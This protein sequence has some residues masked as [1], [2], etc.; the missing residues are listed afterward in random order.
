M[1][2]QSIASH[3][4]SG[5]WLLF[6]IFPLVAAW[7]LADV[8]ARIAAIAAILGFAAV[9][10]A[11]LSRSNIYQDNAPKGYRREFIAAFTAE[12]VLVAVTIALLG[13][14]GLT[15]V[16]FLIPLAIFLF[17]WPFGLILGAVIVISCFVAPW[18]AFGDT[19]LVAF[20]V[21]AVG[22]YVS[23]FLSQFFTE[24][25]AQERELAS[26]IAILDERERVSRDVHDVLGHSLTLISVKSEL[27]TR[28]LERD[29]E[30]ARAE[31]SDITEL[32][33]NAIHE[34]RQT[35][36]GLR[37]RQLSEELDSVRGAAEHAGLTLRVHGDTTDVDPRHRIV[38]A[39]A[40]R[41]AVTNVLRH[42][43]ATRI[44]VTFESDSISIADNG[45]GFDP[46]SESGNG[47]VGLRQRVADAGG[48]L[49]IESGPSGTRL[50]AAM[51]TM[52]ESPS[53]ESPS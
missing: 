45:R 17:E 42:A 16:V 31:L 38:F 29:P 50:T 44:D 52:S 24:R 43:G 28:L 47:L 41:E 21:I 30:A 9:Y 51:K 15:L 10:L 26:R 35:V 3:L 7:N 27:A 5:I 2:K 53:K 14:S 4:A 23:C 22:V 11:V 6:L 25:S 12:I 49:N 39:W 37:V 20:G 34:V 46:D 36:S 1:T 40:L 8:W 32:S 18:L 48:T 33:R 13:E 19:S